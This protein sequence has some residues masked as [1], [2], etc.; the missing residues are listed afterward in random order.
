VASLSKKTEIKRRRKKR[1][2]GHQRKSRQARRSTV[3]DAELFAGCGEP[4][5]PAP[6]AQQ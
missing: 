4:G 6:A 1:R 5:K 2:S 3:S